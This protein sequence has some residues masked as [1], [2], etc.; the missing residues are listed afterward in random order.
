MEHP[1][2]RDSKKL[3][4]NGIYPIN[5]MPD[6]IIVR[7]GGY[8]VY[9]LYIGRKDITGS[10]WG[11]AFADAIGGTHLDSPVGIADVVF[12]KMGINIAQDNY[13]PVRTTVLIRSND[14]L[15]YCLFEENNHR[16]RT[17]DYEWEVNTNGNLVGKDKNSGETCFTW[18]PHGSQFTIH[19]KVPENAVKFTIKRPPMLTKE[20]ILKTIEFDSSW[21]SIIK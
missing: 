16:F 10:D 9:L 20:D 3:V 14:M 11:D 18:Q 13:N 15:N 4:T 21:I 5:E 7:I 6:D 2:L 12:G 8:L 1:K 19:T 17:S